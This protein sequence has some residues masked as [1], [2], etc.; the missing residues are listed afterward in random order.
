MLSLLVLKLRDKERHRHSDGSISTKPIA[1]LNIVPKKKS[2]VI[3]ASLL[4]QAQNTRFL[5]RANA[6]F[7]N[8]NQLVESS[9]SSNIGMT[10]V[11][12]SALALLRFQA[13][14]WSRTRSCQPTR[15]LLHHHLP[16]LRR[17]HT[18]TRSCT[19]RRLAHSL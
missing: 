9:A 7:L 15:H 1:D 19:D 10:S 14:P 5:C 3:D 6:N 16:V 11:A 4:R 12:T 13:R 8:G 2:F 18:S 17:R